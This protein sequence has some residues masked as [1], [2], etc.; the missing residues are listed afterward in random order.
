M[1][2]D[3]KEQGS[4]QLPNDI[5]TSKEEDSFEEYSD[6]PY[7]EQIEETNPRP[8]RD[9]WHRYEVYNKAQSILDRGDDFSVTT[10]RDHADKLSDQS[11]ESITYSKPQGKDSS[12]SAQ[13]C[14]SEDFEATYSS[15]VDIL[16]LSHDSKTI[17]S[18]EI[19]RQ[20][21]QSSNECS[22]ITPTPSGVKVLGEFKSPQQA[23]E[24]VYQLQ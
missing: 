2:E 20:V 24:M 11:D 14:Y 12:P 3:E 4:F 5:G 15:N 1:T 6:L 8:M 9:P 10:I 19:V 16:D 23:T 18:D 21:L 13:D 17:G 7:D 22:P